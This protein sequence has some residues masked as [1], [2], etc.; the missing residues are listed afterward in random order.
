MS[1]R[2]ATSAAVVRVV[3]AGTCW[4]LAAV[5]AK[6]AFDRGVPPVRMAEARVA[7][8]LFFLVLLLAWRERDQLR[9]PPG[10]LPVLVAFGLCVAG[11]NAAYYI[12]IDRLAVGV[13]VSIQYT[14]PVLLLGLAAVTSFRRPE[15]RPRRLAW[16]AA[17]L[18][19]AGAVLVSRAY[20][21][22]HKVDG[23]GLLAAGASALLFG[24]YLLTAGRAGRRG[25]PPATVLFWGFVVATV[26]WS[27]FAPWW[28]WPF[29][30]LGQPKVALA[31]L[32]VGLVGTLVPFF[33]AVGAIRVLTPA[34]AGTA[35]TAEPPAAALF[36]WIFL[37]QHL[38]VVQLVGGTLVMAGVVLAHR[39][40][41][42]TPEALAVESAA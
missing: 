30:R 1:G 14:A 36:A 33:L 11:V 41:V 18:T 34:T 3:A 28:S 31:V 15:L 29:G 8:A 17:A 38:S 39:T 37:G 7:V 27:V 12:A 13:A 10:S 22:F 19:L 26:A 25:V 16:V 24:G 23:K 20:G 35:A 21:G 9:L 2:P 5:M 32:W 42:V 6:V 4:G 40:A